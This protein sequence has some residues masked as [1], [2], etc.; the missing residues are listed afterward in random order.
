MTGRRLVSGQHRRDSSSTSPSSPSR[1]LDSSNSSLDNVSG[2][3]SRVSVSHHD[4][5]GAPVR[6]KVPLLAGEK[7]EAVYEDIAFLCPFSS[8]DTGPIRGTLTITNY[9]LYFR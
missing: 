9:R 3:G 8:S 4:G 2:S 5:A 1:S 6:D 7:I